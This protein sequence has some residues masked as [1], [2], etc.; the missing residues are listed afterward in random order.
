MN[1]RDC[2]IGISKLMSKFVAQIEEENGMGMFDINRISE[3]VLIPLLSEVYGHKNLENLN[4]SEGANFPAIDLGDKETKTAYQITSDPRAGKIKETLEKFVKHKL[5]EKYDR[6]VIY[7]LTKKQSSYKGTGFEEIIGDKFCFDKEN[8]ILDHQDLRRKISGFSLERTRKVE[9]I[10]VDHFGTIQENDEPPDMLEWLEQVNNL[11]GEE[12]GTMKVERERLLND[13]QDFTSRGDGVIIGSPGAG[14]TYLM[15]ELHQHLTAAE[16]PHLLLRIDQLGDGTAETLQQELSYKGDLIEKLKSIPVSGKNAILL[17][18]AFDAAR[19]DQTRKRFL[20][21]IGRAIRELVKWNV[22]VTVRTYDA[23]KSQELLYLFGSPDGTEYQSKEILCRHFTIPPFNEDEILQTL[24]QIGCPKSIYNDGSQDFKNILAN[25]FNLWLL[26]KIL[27]NSNRIPDF[28][29]VHS[30]VQLLDLFWQRRIENESNEHLLRQIADKMVQERSLTVRVDDV[31]DDVDLDKPVRKAAWDKLQSDEIL[32]KISS[33]GQRIAFSHNILFDYAIS[34][35]LIDDEPKRLENFITE[36]PSRPLFLRPSLTYFFTRLWYYDAE[37]FWNAFWHIFPNDQ[38]VHLRLVARLIPTSVIANEARGIKQLMP[39]LEKLQNREQVANEAIVRLLQALQTLQIKRLVS[40]IDFFD[41]ISKDLNDKFAWEVAILTS[42]ILERATHTENKVV[43]DACGR[44][45][46]RLF[47]WI[48]EKKEKDEGDRYN[49]LGSDWAVPL[50]AKT[51]HTNVEKSRTL[52]KKVLELTQE[53]NFLI[54]FLIWLN[55][56]V[57]KIWV[58]D[59]EFAASIYVTVFTHYET[60][61]METTDEM[62]ATVSMRSPRGQDY[63]ICQYELIEHFPKFLPT[64]PLLATRAVIQIV[65]HFDKNVKFIDLGE[66]SDPNVSYACLWKINQGPP[67][68]L[69]EMANMLFQFIAGLARSKES[70]P[71][72]DSLL[73]IF[74]REVEGVFLWKRLLETASRFPKVFAP[75]LFELCITKLMQED[76]EV[77]YEFCLFLRAAAPEFTSGQLRR[78]EESILALPRKAT[79]CNSSGSFQEQKDLLLAQIP[80]N[81]LFTNTAKKIREEMERE[82]RAPKNESPIFHWGVVSIAEN[83]WRWEQ[84]VNRTTPESKELKRLFKSLDK[85]SS[86]WRND[87]PTTAAVQLIFPHLEKVYTIVEKETK[88]DKAVTNLFS[89]D[90]ENCSRVIN[91]LWFKL[92]DCVAILSRVVDDP[93]DPV[94]TFCR[95]VLLHQAKYEE[96]VF[97][98]SFDDFL[99][100]PIHIPSLQH[101]AALGLL[102]LALRHPDAEILD[103]IETLAQ[104]SMV[105]VRMVTAREL[106]MVY[107]KAPEKFWHIMEKMAMD[108]PNRVVQKYLYLTLTQ[109]IAIRKENEDKATRVTWKLLEYSLRSEGRLDPSHAFIPILTKL[110]IGRENSRAFETIEDNFCASFFRFRNS[111]QIRGVNRDLRI[112]VHPEDLGTPNGCEK[113]ILWVNRAITIVSCQIEELCNTSQE[114]WTEEEQRKLLETYAI[115][116]VIISRLYLQ[117]TREKGQADKRTD[118]V[119]YKLYRRF[120]NE[121]KPLLEQVVNFAIDS[122][123]NII[124][125]KTAH[126]FMQVLTSFLSCN[127]KE[128]LHLAAGVAQSS[129]RFDYTLDSIAVRDIVEFVE[130]VL[131]DYRDEVRDGEALEDLLNLLDMFAKTGWTDALKLVWRL[132]EVFR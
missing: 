62:G 89:T 73:E 64:A 33:S 118:D 85:F 80:P 12:S 42:N 29:K 27:K 37:S 84:Y 126:Y 72:L 98:S 75:R 22:V 10:L 63:S 93:E 107:V 97:S 11:W 39:L 102:K 91:S 24:N 17:F 130:I 104:D 87:V 51:Y 26:E 21:L 129:E 90:Q 101:R 47:K 18:D 43:T 67:N 82:S 28:S 119:S 127:P 25:P 65:T 31:Y 59:P 19:D 128:V 117:V 32:A 20:N 70:L 100:S 50:V 108:E 105:S 86:E 5:Y 56:H 46:R 57:D 54:D 78:I 66:I 88:T 120:Y 106:A 8:D 132:D 48:W 74:Y 121:I 92:I 111:I 95:Q 94:F 124:L 35:L 112:S 69:I 4:V 36:D 81:L 14:K 123:Y 113:L 38:S 61:T 7:I 40:W 115:I 53:E 2:R 3:D 55:K 116:E 96:P 34:V 23:K 114:S 99:D 110:G 6:L 79:Y 30:E 71:L 44:V 49:Q 52:L 131:A 125:A 16:I 83:K 1:L 15:K 58:R 68:E 76:F 109:V 41:R 122:E 77:F 13:L 45:G 103:A 60:S 9:R